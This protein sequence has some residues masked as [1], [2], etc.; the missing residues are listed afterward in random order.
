MAGMDRDVTPPPEVLSYY[1]GYPEE[2]RL[3]FGHGRLEFERTKE[4]LTRIL[5]RPPARIVDVG[6][7]AGAYSL[8]LAEQGYEV[9]AATELPP[10]PPRVERD[11]GDVRVNM[12]Y[13]AAVSV[14]G[15]AQGLALDVERGR[16]VVLGEAGVLRAQ[17][18]RKGERV[19][20]NAPG[21]DNRQL[22][23]NILHWLSRV[24]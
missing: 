21:Y 5:P 7:A 23:L 9:H 15:R 17:R 3:R 2:S 11:G 18:E 19:G 16:V 12:E 8:W 6:G 24:L 13:G 20:M 1:D 14:A 10:G 4:I 22:A